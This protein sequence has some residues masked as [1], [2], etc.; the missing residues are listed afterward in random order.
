MDIK[1]LMLELIVCMQWVFIT[2]LYGKMQLSRK[3]VWQTRLRVGRKG[4]IE[5]SGVQLWE[6]AGT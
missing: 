6:S 4:T 2:Y 1:S 3:M 5:N